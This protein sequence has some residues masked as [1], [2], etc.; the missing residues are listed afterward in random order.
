M[1]GSKVYILAFEQSKHKNKIVAN[2][3]A[4]KKAWKKLSLPL[5]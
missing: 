4:A 3:G 5:T 2:I 1:P